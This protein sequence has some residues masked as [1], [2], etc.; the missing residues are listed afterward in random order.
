MKIEHILPATARATDRLIL[1]PGAGQQLDRGVLE[2]L[3]DVA[4]HCGEHAGEYL[5]NAN[6]YRAAP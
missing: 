5:L 1:V 6:T 2:A 4:S 3:L